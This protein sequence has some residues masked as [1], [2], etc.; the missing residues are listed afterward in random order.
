MR[1]PERSSPLVLLLLLAAALPS[2]SDAQQRQLPVAIEIAPLFGNDVVRPRTWAPI[3]L[4]LT[5]RT[6]RAFQ[7]EV[8]LDVKSWR[9]EALAH[10]TRLDLPAGAT[11]QVQLDVYMPDD[12][13]ELK[14]HYVV[15]SGLAGRQTYTS[16][17]STGGAAVVVLARESRLRSVLNGIDSST[18]DEYGS[19]RQVEMPVGSLGYD[20][21]TGEPLAPLTSLGYTPVALVVA[22]SNELEALSPVQRDALKGWVATGGRLLVFP[23][24][25]EAVRQ[26][27]LQSLVGDVT[28]GPRDPIPGTYQS[29][30]PDRANESWIP[31]DT[32]EW[33]DE[34][35][36][37]SRRLGFGRVYLAT[38]DGTVRP[39]V[40][41]HYTRATVASVARVQ[42]ARVRMPMFTFGQA[43]EQSYGWGGPS[44]FQ[45]LRAALDPNESFRP[46]LGFVAILLLFYVILVGPVN[47]RWVAKKN[48]PIFALVTTPIAA[49]GC[50]F[51][52]LVVGYVG[53]GVTMRYRQVQLTEGVAGQ[54][55]GSERTYLSLFLT[56]PTSFDLP[57]A[58]GLRLLR[59]GSPRMPQVVTDGVD[60]SL[61]ELQG[62]L[63]QTLFLRRDDTRD[64]GGTITF[65]VESLRLVGV[66]NGTGMTLRDAVL[67]APGGS[68]YRIGDVPPGG[69]GAIE[70][71]PLVTLNDE[72]W[73]WG[74]G[75][76]DNRA[77]SRALG[78]NSEEGRQTI[79]GLASLAG[80]RMQATTP[81]LF[82][83]IERSNGELAGTFSEETSVHLLRIVVPNVEPAVHVS[84]DNDF[85]DEPAP[86]YPDDLDDMGLP[87]MTDEQNQMVQEAIE[88]SEGTV[89]QSAQEILDEAE[90]MVDS[91]DGL[92][93]GVG[94]DAP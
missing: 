71:Q 14:A 75:S 39:H 3:L 68:V 22:R 93:D 11:R 44:G 72:Q 67:L 36:G 64:L 32:N 88:G 10:R 74:A 15:S 83:R 60:R 55:L 29:R 45:E 66:R 82:A 2:A 56:R 6:Q 80:G 13:S 38:Y 12:G 73:Y 8:Q 37:G 89:G 69:T 23:R 41:A 54:P 63:W 9:S 34:S 91:P 46:A 92:M 19:V 61:E 47:F 90:P 81:L 4:T 17:Y 51:L 70:E 28:L 31:T 65:D 5:N 85:G 24:T 58:E 20:P 33:V 49:L 77:F 52:M 16:P 53:K 94:E 59:E 40:D 1:R 79:Y 21:N 84:R 48:R 87:G 26:P 78:M 7:G 86:I 43:E 62:G 30:P 76:P 18:Q 27:F 42:E 35:F 57:N 25:P 50:L